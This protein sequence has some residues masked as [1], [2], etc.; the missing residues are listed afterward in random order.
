MPIHQAL[1]PKAIADPRVVW[2]PTNTPSV[3]ETRPSWRVA[4]AACGLHFV[5]Y[6]C[7]QQVE[8]GKPCSKNAATE[9]S[10]AWP[11]DVHHVKSYFSGRWFFGFRILAHVQSPKRQSY[12]NRNR[13]PTVMSCTVPCD[14]HHGAVDGEGDRHCSFDCSDCL[15]RRIRLHGPF[16]VLEWWP[17]LWSQGRRMLLVS[18]TQ[19][20]GTMGSARTSLRLCCPAPTRDRKQEKQRGAVKETHVGNVGATGTPKGD[21]SILRAASICKIN[22]RAVR[23]KPN[24]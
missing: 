14:Q 19:A 22:A 16:L 6:V 21:G 5:A 23:I 18:A 13:A 3:Q 17:C 1:F 7:L 8:M 15:K 9:F 10:R 4:N 12:S 24:Q 11:T 2:A 20:G